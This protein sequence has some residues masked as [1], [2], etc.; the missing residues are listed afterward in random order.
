M[1]TLVAARHLF[2][3]GV[4][5]S[6]ARTSLTRLRGHVHRF[7]VVELSEEEGRVRPD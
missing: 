5:W 4:D 3:I 6:Q 1:E 7:V 2:Q